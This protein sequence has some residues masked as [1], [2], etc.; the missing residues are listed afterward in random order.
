MVPIQTCISDSDQDTRTVDAEVSSDEGKSD[1]GYGVI[2]ASG[3]Q[4][5]QPNGLKCSLPG[6]SFY[7]CAPHTCRRE[8][9]VTTPAFY[10]LESAGPC[11]LALEMSLFVG[12][13]EEHNDRH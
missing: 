1:M 2:Q 8:V 7:I 10:V 9:E 11:G 13:M 5:I 6:R 4:S 12:I 3:A